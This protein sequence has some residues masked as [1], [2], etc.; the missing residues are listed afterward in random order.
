M[1]NNK[2]NISQKPTIRSRKIKYIK[3]ITEQKKKEYKKEYIIELLSK[4]RKIRT[5]IENKILVH[6]LSSKVAFFAKLR[7]PDDLT[8]LDKLVG[9]L[10][11]ESYQKDQDIISFGEE[12]DKFYI[13]IEGLVAIYKPLYL[14]KTMKLID[15]LSL[16]NYIKEVQ[17]N[18]LKYDRIKEKNSTAGI[19]IEFFSKIDPESYA[20]KKD[21]TVII[22]EDEKLGEFSEP[23]EF[24]DIAL[25]KRCHRNA[26]IRALKDSKVVSIDKYDYNKILRELEEKRLEN[27]LREFRKAYPLFQYWNLNQLIKLFNCFS[28]QMLNQGDYLYK[29]NEVSDS[30]FIVKTGVFEMYSLLSFGWVNEFFNY[31]I[32]PKQNLV[33]SLD[34]AKMPLKESELMMYYNTLVKESQDSPCVFDHQRVPK[35]I[36]SYDA[37]EEIDI[38]RTN[39]ESMANPFH[40]FKVNCRKIDSREVIGIEDAL[41]VKNRFCF[42]KCVS[43]QAEVEKINIF[44]FLK[45]MNYI[46]G[47][48]NRDLLLDTIAERKLLIFTQ[49]KNGTIQR[50]RELCVKL[51]HRCHHLS[52]IKPTEETKLVV[53]KLK[54]KDLFN[55]SNYKQEI[56][57]SLSSP[58]KKLIKQKTER[59][60]LMDSCTSKNI[61]FERNR[62]I[63]TLRSKFSRNIHKLKR[64][65][66]LK[67]KKENELVGIENLKYSPLAC[68]TRF[69]SLVN[70][71]S[72]NN[73]RGISNITNNSNEMSHKKQG[74]IMNTKDN[75]NNSTTRPIDSSLISLQK[76]KMTIKYFDTLNKGEYQQPEEINDLKNSLSRNNKQFFLS[77]DYNVSSQ[78]LFK[79]ISKMS[80]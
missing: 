67:I 45:L 17:G 35:V 20:L 78:K 68:I 13:L 51:T 9:A 24:G 7:N 48:K 61:N 49:L 65:N 11:Y 40:L 50:N 73:T 66:S 32:T 56:I 4:D 31:I 80:L 39:H 72:H 47:N 10:N 12:G 30:I 34:Q 2:N 69:N 1:D 74:N 64:F 52:D 46:S 54:D 23:F 41:E 33:Y 36:P 5:R 53:M 25:I 27:Q 77:R 60:S 55:Y 62:E 22:E 21:F 75:E 38:I 43:K 70:M 6:Y 76:K 71:C 28:K 44:D 16:M 29:Q 19:D 63:A 18:I 59:I 14:Q 15:Y 79:T 37:I 58:R 57:N 8:K 26:T 3:Q 42:V